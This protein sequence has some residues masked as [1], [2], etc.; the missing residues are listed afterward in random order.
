V[1]IAKFLDCL[2]AVGELSIKRNENGEI[3]R[4]TEVVGGHALLLGCS[5]L[6]WA[7]LFWNRVPFGTMF[8]SVAKKFE[9]PE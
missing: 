7:C 2:G 4:R 1:V 5:P 9:L 3:K 6:E 8:L